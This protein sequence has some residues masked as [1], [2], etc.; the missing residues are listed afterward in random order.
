MSER[1]LLGYFL[2]RPRIDADV[3][4]LVDLYRAGELK[5]DEVVSHRLDLDEIGLG[6]ERLRAGTA[7]RQVVVF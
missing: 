5:L 1:N 3:P 7:V 6:L 2:G 4:R